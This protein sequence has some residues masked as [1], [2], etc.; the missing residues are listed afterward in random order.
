MRRLVNKR[1]QIWVETVIYTL[2]GL[3]IIGIVLAAAK[4]KIDAKKDEIIIEQAIE[5]LGNINDKIYE[6]QRAAGNRRAVRLTIGK[7]K[8]IIDMA[9]D[10]ISWV[11]ESSFEYSEKDMAVSLGSL[12]VL[13]K[14]ST[15]WE[16]TLEEDYS[17]D[18][19]FE[20]QTAGTKE[21]DAASTPYELIIENKGIDDAGNLVIDLSIA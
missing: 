9:E 21:L 18:L 19:Q 4:P 20:E 2:I 11:I 15:P 13:T 8:F 12:E 17:I 7:G 1:G 5:A 3:A 14:E 16:V 10:K 6:V